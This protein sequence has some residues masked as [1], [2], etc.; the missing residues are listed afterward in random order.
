MLSFCWR[1]Q[2]GKSGQVYD[3]K[4]RRKTQNYPLVGDFNL[5]NLTHP[6]AAGG[7][8]PAVT[9]QPWP[10]WHHFHDLGPS[11]SHFSCH[12]PLIAKILEKSGLPGSPHHSPHSHRWP[13]HVH[14]VSAPNLLN[15]CFSL[16]WW[17][18]N[19]PKSRCTA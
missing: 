3:K 7:A 14:S 17:E 16:T 12:M 8:A 11:A 10:W 4:K 6:R 13:C 1:Q 2:P 18:R 19:G 9:P 5:L 15:S